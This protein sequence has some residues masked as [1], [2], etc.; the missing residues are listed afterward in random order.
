MKKMML[1]LA[2]ALLLAGCETKEH[3]DAEL[4]AVKKAKEVARQTQAQGNT[5]AAD[6]EI[7]VNEC[8]DY[9][10]KVNACLDAKVPADEQPAIRFQ[11]DSQ[12]TKWGKMALDA[13][14]RDT[15][16]TECKAA[17][18]LGAQSMEKY[19]CEF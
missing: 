19:G 2:I 18:T 5:S 1:A 7:G 16:P 14:Q 12:K 4:Q 15:L 11:L 3:A 9:V 17:A 10:R 13:A 8:D 6:E